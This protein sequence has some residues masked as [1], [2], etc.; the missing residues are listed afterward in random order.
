ML[1]D[2]GEYVQRLRKDYLESFVG[3]GG[4]AVKF[5]AYDNTDAGSRFMAELSSAADDQG[6]L[7][8]GLD[9]RRVRVHLVNEIYVA[10]SRAID[11]DDLAAR[12]VQRGYRQL[13]LHTGLDALAV[14]AV[15][16]AQSLVPAELYRSMRR[17][18][19]RSVLGDPRLTRDFRVAVLR[20]CQAKLDWGEVDALEHAAVLDW[21]TGRQV[22]PVRL[23]SLGIGSRIVR[24]N[25]RHLLGSLGHWVRR[26]GNPGLVL[27]LDVTRLGVT[28]RP[29]QRDGHHYTKAM[30]LDAYEVLRQF[31]DSLDELAGVLLVVVLPGGMAH[32]RQRGLTAYRALH[33]R[34]VSEISDRRRANP[35][36]SLVR[37]T[38]VRGPVS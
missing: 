10:L 18:L 30:T 32:D 20:L 5:V 26:A 19:E 13:G 9:A 36:A 35:M 33:Q 15:A 38:D 24:H 2:T 22:S 14:R 1:L 29:P 3:D 6:Y 8:F 34:V 37:I 11:W 16:E 17:Y 31:I 25:A 4:S 23:R 21:L 28:R 12:F 7:H 27:R